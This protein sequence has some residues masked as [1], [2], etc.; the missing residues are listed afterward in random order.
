MT[1]EEMEK[2]QMVIELGDYFNRYG[3]YNVFRMMY[4]TDSLT[5]ETVII[6]FKDGSNKSVNVHRDSKPTM[7]EDILKSLKVTK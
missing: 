1:R 7:L 3:L 5:T 2:S 6:F 4:M